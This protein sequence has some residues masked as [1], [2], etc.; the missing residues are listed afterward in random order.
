M[1]TIRTGL[2]DDVPLLGNALSAFIM[3]VWGG[4]L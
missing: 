3:V 1:E 4:C 2:D